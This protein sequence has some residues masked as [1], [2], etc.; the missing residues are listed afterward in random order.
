MFGLIIYLF[1]LINIIRPI[2]VI[3]NYFLINSG[4]KDLLPIFGLKEMGINPETMDYFV[5]EVQDKI[6]EFK[7]IKNS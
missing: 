7:N 3:I 5:H 4:T 2:L 6:L 1:I